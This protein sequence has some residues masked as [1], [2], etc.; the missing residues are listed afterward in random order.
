MK[1]DQYPLITTPGVIER[2]NGMRSL[3]GSGDPCS[4]VCLGVTCCERPGEVEI[5]DGEFLGKESMHIVGIKQR[6]ACT[7]DQ[8]RNLNTATAVDLITFDYINKSKQY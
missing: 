4:H 5:Q 1:V 7:N 6:K 2:P 3:S 8:D